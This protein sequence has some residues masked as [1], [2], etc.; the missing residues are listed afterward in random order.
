MASLSPAKTYQRITGL[1][2]KAVGAWNTS[3]LR[4]YAW[5]VL[6]V[7][8]IVLV[9]ASSL[10]AWYEWPSNSLQIQPLFLG[11]AA[12]IYGVTYA[13]HTIGWHFLAVRLFGP[14]PLNENAEAVAA[15]NLV[16]SLPTVAWYIASRTDFYAQR[17]VPRKRV[18]AGA[19]FELAMMIVSGVLLFLIV[20]AAS[21]SLWLIVPIL[22]LVLALWIILPRTNMVLQQLLRRKFGLNNDGDAP[23][24]FSAYWLSMLAWYGIVWLMGVGFVWSILRSVTPIELNKL[25]PLMDIW[26]VA[27]LA[28]YAI[29]LS[30]GTLGIAREITLTFLLTQHWSLP[31]AIATAILI[32]IALTF[33]E[34][35][36]S[37]LVL[38]MVRL[39]RKQQHI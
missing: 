1:L 31:I 4:P 26:L 29:S 32:K 22:V 19:M 17:Q 28:G 20:R 37:V 8:S 34:L 6:S 3:A 33:G 30:L 14:I 12:V 36:C 35:G 23:W 24:Q 39:S 16:K 11:L 7:I 13:M 21:I 15:S 27:C 5:R 25:L 9:S 18:V 2:S 10:Y 38:A